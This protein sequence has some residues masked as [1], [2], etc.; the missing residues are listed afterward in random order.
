MPYGVIIFSLGGASIIPSLEN[1]L[2]KEIKE[3][4]KI[5]FGWIGAIGTLVPMIVYVIFMFTVVGISGAKTSAEALQGLEATLG[6]GYVV[7][8][9]II[10]LLALFTSFIALGNELKRIFSSI[11]DKSQ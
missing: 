2:A 4:K 8:G 9:A 6:N 3:K 10:G 5:H 11:I 1:I 7:I